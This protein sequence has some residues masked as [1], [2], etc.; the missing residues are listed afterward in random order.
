I[1]STVART[2]AD[3]LASLAAYAAAV[4]AALAAQVLL[5]AMVVRCGAGLAVGGFFR[6]ISDALLLAFST[7]SSNA[8][9]PV[10]IAAAKNR[11]DIPNEVAGF[12]LPAGVTLN[13]KG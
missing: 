6:A 8:A 3:L 12:V 2:G 13:K 11:L 4:V 1:A 10:S 9:L 5:L 7:A